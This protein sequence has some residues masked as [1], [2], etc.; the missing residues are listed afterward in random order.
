M[1]PS[2]L[3][4]LLLLLGAAPIG[5]P[6]PSAAEPGSDG[7]VLTP[8][9]WLPTTTPPPPSCPAGTFQAF[10]RY[11]P[12]ICIAGPMRVRSTIANWPS[13]GCFP[14]HVGAGG[15]TN[16]IPTGAARE[17]QCPGFQGVVFEW[18]LVEMVPQRGLGNQGTEGC[19]G[20][21]QIHADGY[22]PNSSYSP[23]GLPRA[24]LAWYRASG[25]GFSV[26]VDAGFV[27]YYYFVGLES[28]QCYDLPPGFVMDRVQCP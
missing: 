4:A 12:A 15:F 22:C 3:A 2:I 19:Y 20:A 5:A 11:Q 8:T 24:F 17:V 6:T 10:A 14:L 7:V 25:W 18:A 13:A 26:I 28:T 16:L 9:G 21:W 1:H 23:D 27:T